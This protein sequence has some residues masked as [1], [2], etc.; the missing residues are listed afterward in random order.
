M[1]ARKLVSMPFKANNL[2]WQGLC[3]MD[4][5]GIRGF[6]KNKDVQ[7]KIFSRTLRAALAIAMVALLGTG[8]EKNEVLAPAEA[9]D[10][11]SGKKEL[12][13]LKFSHVDPAFNKK[14]KR[15]KM[16]NKATGEI[17]HLSHGDPDGRAVNFMYGNSKTAPYNVYKI[18]PNNGITGEVVGQLAFASEAIALHP[19]TGLLYYLGRQ[20]DDDGQYPVGVWDPETN[21]N[22]ILPQGSGFKP[23]GKLA[24]APNGTLYGVSARYSYRMYTINTTTGAWAHFRSYN[25]YLGRGGDL[26]FSADGTFFN[27]YDADYGWVDEI[28]LNSNNI[29]NSVYMGLTSVNGICFGGNGKAYIS[30]ND[31]SI[32]EVNINN[33][34][35][36]YLGSIAVHSLADLAPIIAHTELSFAEISLEVLP[37]SIDVTKEIEITL[38]TTELSGGVA[39]TFQP[40]GTI[41][42]PDAILNIE[43]HGVDLSGVDPNE[44]DIYY[45]NQE[46]GNWELMQC[47]DI[48]VDAA[49]GT[50]RVVNARLPHFSRYAI[51]AD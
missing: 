21:T 38:E 7:M 22:T 17:L 18:D 37:N 11:T 2:I 42:A 31:G 47:D 26:T 36:D 23:A 49:S 14:K 15:K 32:Y 8:C 34:T 4:V 10:L 1:I 44:V 45:D 51:A 24:F 25:L 12:N 20:R 46:T 39:V 33:G 19:Q 6:T 13:F 5:R 27:V 30:R 28:P 35:T 48:I 3:I 50:V 40:H 41:F 16:V 9:S 29:V 43:A